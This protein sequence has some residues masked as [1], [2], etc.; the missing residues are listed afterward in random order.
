[1]LIIISM[2]KFENVTFIAFYLILIYHVN[3]Y[4]FNCKYVFRK[5]EISP[6]SIAIVLDILIGLLNY[7]YISQS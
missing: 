3:L 2:S 1:M 4:F 5:Q 6:E 7:E